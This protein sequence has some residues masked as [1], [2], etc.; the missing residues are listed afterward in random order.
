MSGLDYK[1]IG[2]KMRDKRLSLGLKQ[3]YVA[4]K[5]NVNPS[6][7]S[8]IE[9]GRAHPSLAIL[10]KTA[11]IF[12]CSV[13]CFLDDEYRYTPDNPAGLEE[14]ISRLLLNKS[15]E[16]REKALKILELL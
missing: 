14:R 6:H 16:E 9:C 11:E 7:I 13:D 1:R 12:R 2:K 10:V 5:L 15:D 3:E 8:N 4:E